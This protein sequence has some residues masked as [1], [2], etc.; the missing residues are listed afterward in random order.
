M[1]LI[2]FL[3]QPYPVPIQNWK[4][5]TAISV[6]VALIIYFME[7]FGLSE[8]A[9][10]NKSLFLLGYGLITYI[11]LKLLTTIVTN[12]FEEHKWNVFNEIMWFLSIVLLIGLLNYFY[13]AY[14]LGFSYL[15]FKSFLH[16][17][18][19]TLF[20]AIFPCIFLVVYKQNQLLKKNSNSAILINKSLETEH[21]VLAPNETLTFIADN[22]K[23]TLQ[24]NI[25]Q[26]VFV[27][28]AGNYI[29][30]HINES[31]VIVTKTLRSTLSKIESVT[32]SHPNLI[33]CH[34]AFVVNTNYIEH[35]NGNAQGFRL[36]IKNSDKLV[37]VSRQYTQIIKNK[38]AK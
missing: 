16:F 37:Y 10:K 8:V 38:L 36:S 23:E 18:A 4:L 33:K 3:K 32:S 26:L 29:D 25:D 5:I 11:A 9:I 20:V 7:P 27:E 1:D 35:V 31:G 14:F 34:R 2:K 13:T 17:Q 28:S 6:A 30:I 24:I 22:G 15:N 12:L 19:Y 21:E